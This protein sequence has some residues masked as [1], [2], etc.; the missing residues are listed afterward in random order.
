MSCW[1]SCSKAAWNL[2]E[3]C[4]GLGAGPSLAW[5]AGQGVLWGGRQVYVDPGCAHSGTS[6]ARQI[7]GQS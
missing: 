2:P 3:Q 7:P 6:G 1:R 4:W 5:D